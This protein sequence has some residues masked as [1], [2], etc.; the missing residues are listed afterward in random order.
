MKTVTDEKQ[1]IE[2]GTAKG[3]LR[4]YNKHFGTSFRVLAQSDAPDI[5]CV[6]DAG[7]QLGLEI[8]ATEDSDRD[9]QALLGRSD[10]KS[11]DALTAQNERVASGL[12]SPPFVS[13][14]D[15]K[16]ALVARITSK[17]N[18][19]YGSNVALVV[20]D[21]S[22]CEE[23]ASGLDL[24]RNPFDKGIWVLTRV[25]DKLFQIVGSC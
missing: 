16:K 20:R 18:R 5:R 23:V 8:T 7:H 10:H 11:I 22:G 9:I 24:A 4:L 19:D 3:F 17:F 25:M 12:H 14:E 1:R 2:L 13:F 21:T 6:D 15:V